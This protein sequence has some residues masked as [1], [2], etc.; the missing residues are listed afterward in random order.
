MKSQPE[1]IVAYTHNVSDGGI[2]VHHLPKP[3]ETIRAIGTNGGID[4]GKGTNTAVAASRTGASVALVASVPGGDWYDRGRTILQA[5][6][7]NDRFVI[8]QPGTHKAPGCMLIDDEGNN[9]IVLPGG[10][11]QSIPKEQIDDAL[12]LFK[13]AKYCVTGYELAENSVRIILEEAKK[14]GVRTILNPS[15]VPCK[16]PDFW[17]S[18]DILIL[19]EV[20]AAH[21]LRLACAELSEDWK[22]NALALQRSYCCRQ[23]V[24]TLGENG[25]FSLDENGITTRINGYAVDPTDTTGA[26]DGFLGA[27]AARLVAGDTLGEACQWANLFASYSV[28]GSG[29]I[30]SYPSREEIF[31]LRINSSVSSSNHT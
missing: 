4:C 19:N 30:S 20:E 6:Q 14:F 17:N 25:F 10:N 8:C 15:P 23:V 16:R 24:I 12:S 9:M 31:Q 21:M 2:R 18:I 28:Q 29:T 27:M 11:S 7:V 13:N 5:E 3:G 22:E 26:G 1:I